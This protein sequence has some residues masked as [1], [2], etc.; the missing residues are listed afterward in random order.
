MSALPSKL[1]T[2]VALL[3]Q[4][5]FRF[6]GRY[7]RQQ[8]W[9][10]HDSFGLRRDLAIPFSPPDAKIPMHGVRPLQESDLPKLF[11]PDASPTGP[12]TEG[13][14]TQMSLVHADIATCYVAITDDDQPC[15]MQWLIGP[16][17]NDKVMRY[18]KGLFAPL[19]ADEVLLEGAYVPP[20][21]RGL[22]INSRAMASI[23]AHGTDLGARWAITYIGVEN[24]PSIRGAKGAG[25]EPYVLRRERWRF[26]RRAVTF[27]PLPNTPATTST[28]A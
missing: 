28:T 14:R 8:L 25:F 2:L 22:R 19:A 3:R 21:F 11:D 18:F 10:Q 1:A 6:I 9:S 23:A 4:G 20:R 17:E 15:Y 5:D 26:F 24:V 7:L 12:D 16:G 13:T 27:G